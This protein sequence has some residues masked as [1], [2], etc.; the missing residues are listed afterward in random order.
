MDETSVF[1]P[2]KDRV[3]IFSNISY[4]ESESNLC[5]GM[6]LEG[7]HLQ[8]SEHLTLNVQLQNKGYV[9]SSTPVRAFLKTVRCNNLTNIIIIILM[10]FV[11]IVL[12]IFYIFYYKN[13]VTKL[14][15]PFSDIN[16]YNYR[17]IKSWEYVEDGLVIAFRME[18]GTANE[19]DGS[20]YT[21]ISCICGI[22]LSR[23]SPQVDNTF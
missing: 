4:S 22:V 14:Y 9:D 21:F 2:L 1:R 13:G 23:Q 3:L 18:G 20:S 15:L 5:E 7:C 6:I 11:N 10:I 8:N 16:W 17:A 12:M 19:H